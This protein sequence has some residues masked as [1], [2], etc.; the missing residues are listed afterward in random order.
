MS[1]W[2]TPAAPL[3]SVGSAIWASSA[4]INSSWSVAR[5]RTSPRSTA[6]S[7]APAS[8]SSAMLACRTEHKLSAASTK[9]GSSNV[10]GWAMLSRL[11]N[12]QIQNTTKK[13]N[14]ANPRNRGNDHRQPRGTVSRAPGSSWG[15]WPFVFASIPVI[16]HRPSCGAAVGPVS[17][18][19]DPPHEASQEYGPGTGSVCNTI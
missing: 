2:G 13:R 19:G 5:S 1:H 18:R 4:T 14:T 11:A 16:V 12:A 3:G 7:T 10:S 8:G 6:F 9:I 15:A 17:R